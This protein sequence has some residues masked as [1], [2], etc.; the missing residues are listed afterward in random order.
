[1]TQ[2][3]QTKILKN[4]IDPSTSP[5]ANPNF[6]IMLKNRSRG[7]LNGKEMREV[8]SRFNLKLKKRHEQIG[9]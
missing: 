7:N 9:V 6:K 5:Y 1:M 8:E 2:R 4:K 3:N